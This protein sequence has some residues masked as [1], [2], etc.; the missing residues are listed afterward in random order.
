MEDQMNFFSKKNQKR[1]VRI[2]AII[3]VTAMVI[4]L[5]AAVFR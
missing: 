5:L 1:I 4:A 3:L 2:L